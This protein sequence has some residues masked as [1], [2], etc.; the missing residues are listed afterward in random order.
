[1]KFCGDGIFYCHFS[2]TV[3]D[4]RNVCLINRQLKMSLFIIPVPP[5]LRT[6]SIFYYHFFYLQCVVYTLKVLINRELNC[7][8]FMMR[9]PSVF[10]QM[11]AI[12]CSVTKL[13]FSVLYTKDSQMD[14]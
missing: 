3:R 7:S 12:I 13:C 1:M 9:V 4:I 14:S 10:Q 2:S 8:L 5:L 6:D 11:Y